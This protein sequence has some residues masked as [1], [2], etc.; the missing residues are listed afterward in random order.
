MK[1]TILK[2]LFTFWFSHFTFHISVLTVFSAPID[3]QLGSR[4]QGLGGAFTAI[5]DDAN[6]VAW[7][8]AGLS[9]LNNRAFT[10]MHGMFSEFPFINMDYLGYVQPIGEGGMGLGWQNVGSELKEGISQSSSW[11]SENS[12]MLAYGTNIY[13][14]ISFGLN[15]KLLTIDSNA[16][17]G[18]GFGFDFGGLWVLAKGKLSLGAV[19]KNIVAGF[20]NESFSMIYRFGIAGRLCSDL[21]RLA[22]DIEIKKGIQDQEGLSTKIHS[23]IE[24]VIKHKYKYTYI[25]R[26][27]Y[28]AGNATCGFGGKFKNVGLDYTFIS[29]RTFG[30]IHR[31]STTVMWGSKRT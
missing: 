12:F 30:A 6:A 9:Q 17:G 5:S 18:A 19:V 11:M 23:G 16:G 15:L 4:P 24:W 3:L 27:G 7:N 8:P 21:L 20:K 14:K 13:K 2:Y 1:R 31:I 28:D 25:L 26:A 22:L 10:F 29:N